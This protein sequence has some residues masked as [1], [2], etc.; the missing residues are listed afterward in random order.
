[1]RTF[2]ICILLQLAVL[3]ARSESWFEKKINQTALYKNFLDLG[4]P[5]PALLRTFQFLDSKEKNIFKVKLNDDERIEKTI[6]NKT[7]AVVINY[8]Q[9]SSERRL[10]LLNLKDGT[11]EKYYVAHGMNSGNNLAKSFSNEFD[12]RK[13]SLGFYLTGSEFQGSHGST[14][15][16]HGVE[17]SN[18]NAFQRDIVMHGASYVSIDFLE[19]NGRMG[20][21]WGCPAVSEAI[22]EKIIPLIK[23]G[24]LLYM[25]HDSLVPV[26]KASTSVE[27][28][29]CDQ[30]D[31]SCNS[32]DIMAE[33]ILPEM[34][35]HQSSGDKSNP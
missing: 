11:V 10:Y 29:G 13:T 8:S 26:A 6:Q 12:S 30:Q 34:R 14:L 7:Y 16:L 22:A 32:N 31:A 28:M 35:S 4:V 17:K 18:D 23:G 5:E 1:M 20:R 33:E 3:P 25:Y 21:S 27:E 24:S 15:Y 9:P 2:I 19:A